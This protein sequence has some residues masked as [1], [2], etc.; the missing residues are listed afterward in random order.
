MKIAFISQPWNDVLPPVSAG[1][2]AI[3]NYQAANR[4]AKS[5]DVTIY[6]RRIGSQMR[7]E[8]YQGVNYRRV[9]IWPDIWMNRF[10][11]RI[12]RAGEKTPF[13]SS[14][15][16]YLLFIFRVAI[17]M[18]FGRSRPDIVHINNLSQFVPIVRRFL[19]HAHIV[20][21][22][23]CEWLTQLEPSLID[24]RL[25]QT[26]LVL[27]CSE[28]VVQQ[29]RRAFPHQASKCKVIYNAVDEQNFQKR[30][31]RKHKDHEVIKILYV[32]RVSPEKG[33][34]LLVDAFEKVARQRPNTDLWIVGPDAV[35]PHDYLVGLGDDDLVGGLSKFYRVGCSY[36]AMLEAAISPDIASQVT[37]AGPVPHTQLEEIYRQAD[38]LVNPSLS[39]AFGMCLVEAM[40]CELPVVASKVGGMKEIVLD[41]QTGIFFESGNVAGLVDALVYLIDNAQR[42]RDFGQMGRRRVLE[43]FTWD[44][45]TA[46]LLGYYHSLLDER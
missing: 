44:R 8:Q 18:R 13:F 25:S 11:K 29:V 4:L 15:A 22:M 35:T 39:E 7:R 24:A 14:I 32:G 16:Y 40:A 33:I 37:L 38:I 27:G 34:H 17:L 36:R 45:I 21:H 41:Q 3:W 1:S 9:W 12:Y 10:L 6:A 5:H 42:R 43:E 20:L 26:D 46:N 2:I 19:P 23:Q 28:H 31:A 30:G